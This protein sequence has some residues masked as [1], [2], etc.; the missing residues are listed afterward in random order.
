MLG[1]I[2]NNNNLYK[3]G[4]RKINNININYYKQ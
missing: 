4:L 1:N 2:F 3:K